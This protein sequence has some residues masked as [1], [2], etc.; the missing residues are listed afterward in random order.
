MPTEQHPLNSRC[1]YYSYDKAKPFL[2][3]LLSFGFG[4]PVYCERCA[5]P[6]PLA[7]IVLGIQISEASL[8]APTESAAVQQLLRKDWSVLRNA[9]RPADW[10]RG[11]TLRIELGR[12][13]ACCGPFCSV[14]KVQGVS[15]NKTLLLG[16]VF[17]GEL[18]GQETVMLLEAA[19]VGDLVANENY[20]AKAVATCRALGSQLDF[21]QLS[22][23]RE[24]RLEAMRVGHS[25]MV[26]SQQGRLQQA[27]EGLQSALESFTRLGPKGYQA[28]TLMNMATVHIQL[29]DLDQAAMEL[30]RSIAISEEIGELSLATTCRGLVGVVH[31]L[32]GNLD[33]AESMLCQV[34]QAETDSNNKAGMAAAHVELG[35]IYEAQGRHAQARGAYTRGLELWQQLGA[36]QAAASAKAALARLPT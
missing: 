20:L 2:R 36:R 21:D 24:A 32:R 18:D 28:A 11:P 12:C 33:A 25:A 27:I 26:D 7:R 17:L 29:K 13:D 19:L 6:V 34:V 3:R 10:Y 15:A 14:G 16:A 23:D 1:L 8:Q 35:E 4:W 30:Q 22:A 31:R 5:K 9:R